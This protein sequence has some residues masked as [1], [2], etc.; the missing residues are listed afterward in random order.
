MVC[1]LPTTLIYLF[2][3]YRS[4]RGSGVLVQWRHCVHIS[5]LG[6]QPR[7]RCSLPSLYLGPP[8]PQSPCRL[9]P[10]HRG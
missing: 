9:H 5:G 4:K 6:D 3:G 8:A 1:S 10:Y 7:P 2:P